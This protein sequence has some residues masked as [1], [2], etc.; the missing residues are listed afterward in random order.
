[1]IVYTG[2][3]QAQLAQIIGIPQSTLS[4]YEREA[5]D[6]PHPTRS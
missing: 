5:G 2:L 3:S 6:I 1:M 4:F